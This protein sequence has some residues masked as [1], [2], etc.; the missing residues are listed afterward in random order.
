M[1][2][3]H[4]SDKIADAFVLDL[5]DTFKEIEALEDAGVIKAGRLQA[6][7][8][9]LQIAIMVHIGDPEDPDGWPDTH[10]AY[11]PTTGRKMD[12]PPTEVGGGSFW[13]RRGTVEFQYFGLK[14]KKDRDEA[15]RIANV[16]RGRI[17]RT[18]NSST[19]VPGTTDSFG[20]MAM[21]SMS[22]LSRVSEGGGPPNSFIWRGVVRYQVRTYRDV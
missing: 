9:K 17:E 21:Q 20:E 10:E 11:N 12:V 19:R 5:K 3:E 14:G 4:I 1:A 6:D 18:I 8:V 15:R 16:T 13:W 7:P 22:T 2:D